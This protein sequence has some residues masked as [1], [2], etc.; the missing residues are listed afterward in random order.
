MTGIPLHPLIVHFPIVL[1]VL[2][3]ISAL[4]ALWAIRKG[5][6]ARRAWA[7]PLV[8]AAALAGSAFVA[9]E[10]GEGDEERVEDIV[11]DRAS[12]WSP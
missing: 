3:P 7:A 4:V 5:A 1:A 9:T 11:G 10:T 2:L 12:L 8:I 6:T